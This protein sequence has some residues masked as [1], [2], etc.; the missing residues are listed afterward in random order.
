MSKVDKMQ[1]GTNI[2]SDVYFSSS[3]LSEILVYRFHNVGA[4]SYTLSDH[5]IV[6]QRPAF[7]ILGVLVC[8]KT[9]YKI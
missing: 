2:L 6:P 7:Y 1:F 9:Q 3:C 5:R 8:I 4:F